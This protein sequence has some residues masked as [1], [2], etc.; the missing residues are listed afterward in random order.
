MKRQLTTGLGIIHSACVMERVLYFVAGPW[1][2]SPF[3]QLLPA[4]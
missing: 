4:Q 2:Y 3:S 1:F